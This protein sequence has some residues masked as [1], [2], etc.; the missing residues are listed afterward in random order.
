MRLKLLALIPV[1][2][3]AFAIDRPASPDDLD[4]F[5]MKQMEQRNIA[6]LSLAVVQD[7]RIVTARAYGLTDR[8]SARRVDTTTLFQAGSISKS[9]AALGALHLVEQGKLDLDADVN[10]KLTSW[11]LPASTFTASKPVTLRG[12]LSHTAGLTVHGFPG[13]DVDSAMPTL[14]QVLDGARP[15]NTPAIRNDTMPGARWNYSGGGYT[16]MQ[17]MMIDVTGEPFPQFMSHTVLAPLGMARSSYE[18]PLPAS[19]ASNTAAGHYA[20]G[21]NVHA[22]WHIYPEMAA[23]GLWTTPSD[24]ARFAIAVQE[25]YAGRSSAVIS[26]AMAKQ[27][28]TEQKDK[29][30]LGVFL[31]RSGHELRF[32]HNGRDEG[33]DAL[34]VATAETGQAFA[35]MINANDDSRM[36]ARILSFVEQK[37][38]WPNATAY[39]PP[40]AVSVPVADL[41]SV[42]GLYDLGNGGTGRLMRV[43]ERIYSVAGG[44]PDEEFIPTGRDEFAS[45]ERASTITVTRDERGG[46]VRLSRSAGGAVRQLQRIGPLFT[47]IKSGAP[48]DPATD[49]RVSAMLRAAA[50]GGGAMDTL[51]VLSPGARK[52]LA[53]YQ[54]PLFA[55]FQRVIP[56]GDFDVSARGIERHQSKVARVRY[57]RVVM[58]S[59]EEFVLIYLTSDGLIADLDIAAH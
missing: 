49:A 31:E 48:A 59:S 43:G 47:Q 12:L 37:Y 40:A 17:Q 38:H 32:F 2:T 19:M 41:E 28:L 5:V 23:A 30:G 44:R 20:E 45:A 56:V 42:A 50:S 1:A 34:L 36:P 27:M 14:V 7:G 24:L 15:A 11:K 39:T 8:G 46:V 53:G 55:G 52:D 9:V 51:T 58:P 29:D 22:R 26:Q 3:L 33:F 57:Y 13:Y 10:T 25:A 16:I 54:E 35:L 21:K 18:Q 4:S 6:G